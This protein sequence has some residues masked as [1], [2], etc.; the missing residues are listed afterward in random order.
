MRRLWRASTVAV[1]AGEFKQP[2]VF[3]PHLAPS[4]VVTHSTRAAAFR[5]HASHTG[6]LYLE[7]VKSQKNVVDTVSRRCVLVMFIYRD[8]WSYVW[9][10]TV[11]CCSQR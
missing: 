8:L 5:R 6:H 3:V 10:P 11:V 2:F 9:R 1:A 4:T 7:A